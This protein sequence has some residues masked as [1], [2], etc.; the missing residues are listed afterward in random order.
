MIEKKKQVKKYTETLEKGGRGDQFFGSFVM[1]VT[2]FLSPVD[3]LRLSLTT[4]RSLSP[5]G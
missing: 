4:L 1:S 2:F 3:A 5:E